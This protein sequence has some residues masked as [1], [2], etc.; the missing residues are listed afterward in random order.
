[1][2]DN[3]P[4]SMSSM[5]V[6]NEICGKAEETAKRACELAERVHIKLRTVMTSECP[7]PVKENEVAKREY[8]PLFSTLDH[9]LY[10]INQALDS[11]GEA[12]RRTEL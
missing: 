5:S 10:E 1:M 4:V 2:K 3:C 11:I 8:P 9:N 6:A 7:M 12:L